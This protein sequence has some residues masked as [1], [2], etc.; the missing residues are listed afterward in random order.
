MPSLFNHPLHLGSV[1]P[2]S[3]PYF[4]LNIFLLPIGQQLQVLSGHT[5]EVTHT[6]AASDRL[7]HVALLLHIYFTYFTLIFCFRRADILFTLPPPIIF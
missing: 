1:K 3:L 4:G 7:I 5:Q 2:L 6:A